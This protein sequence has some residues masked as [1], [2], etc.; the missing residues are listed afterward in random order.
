[1]RPL[2]SRVELTFLPVDIL[3]LEQLTAIAAVDSSSLHHEIIELLI[4]V[5]GK[6]VSDTKRQRM[7]STI[8]NAFLTLATGVKGAHRRDALLR[9]LLRLHKLLLQVRR[10]GRERSVR[11]TLFCFFQRVPPALSDAD[12]ASSPLLAAAGLLL[13]PIARL[14]PDLTGVGAVRAACWRAARARKAAEGGVDEPVGLDPS[15][16]TT[17]VSQTRIANGCQRR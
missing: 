16:V 3:L 6:V 13:P 7:P 9:R 17:K 4:S 14:L 1:M 2:I 15:E 8:T 12:A 11:S 10:R 5:F